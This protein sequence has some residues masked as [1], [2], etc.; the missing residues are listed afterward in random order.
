MKNVKLQ[1]KGFAVVFMVLIVSAVSLSVSLLLNE[2][3][4]FANT[5][6]KNNQSYLTALYAAEACVERALL[7]VRDETG[8]EGTDNYTVGIIEC[9][10]IVT[11][12]GGNERRLEATATSGRATANVAVTTTTLSPQLEATWIDSASF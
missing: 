9:A 11:D 2:R 6:S 1:P 8:Y 10:V 4:F 7:L 12:E 5:T 3:A